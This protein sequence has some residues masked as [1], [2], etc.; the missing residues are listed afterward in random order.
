VC[1]FCAVVER[2]RGSGA[3]EAL[4]QGDLNGAGVGQLLAY[5]FS[6]SVLFGLT[7]FVLFIACSQAALVDSFCRMSFVVQ[8]SI[9]AIHGWNVL[10][11]LL[12]KASNT[13]SR[14]F[15][16]LQTTFFSVLL[17]AMVDLAHGFSFQAHH[18]IAVIPNA[19]I[20][21]GIVPIFIR[22]ASITERCSLVPALLNS[23][24]CGDEIDYARQYVVDYIVNSNAGF[25]VFNIRITYAMVLKAFYILAALSIAFL[26]Q[27]VSPLG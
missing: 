2:W 26:N 18:T 22:A 21:L 11:A 27:V 25:H 24:A 17:L 16:V 6:I 5:I 19:V 23:Q 14:C 8:D 4:L 10:T 3:F 20:C 7:L 15:M 13:V 9:Q 12:R 1:W